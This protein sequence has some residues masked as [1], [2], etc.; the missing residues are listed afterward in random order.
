MTRRAGGWALAEAVVA[1]VLTAV[2]AAAALG[3]LVGLQRRVAGAVERAAMASGLRTAAQVIHA[4]LGSVDPGAGDLVTAAPDRMIY[5]AVRGNGI[6][7]G[8]TTDGI[9]VRT[10]TWRSLRLP[11]P[12][13]DSVLALEPGG[14]WRVAALVGPVRSATCPDGSSGLVLPMA[15]APSGGAT[16]VRTFEVMELR[17]YV[18]G[19]DSWLGLR[20]VSSGEAIQPVAG[21]FRASAIP[22]TYLD[23]SG[24]PTT[25]PHLVRRVRAVFHGITRAEGAA[26][27][28]ARAD[29]TRRDSVETVV[30]LRGGTPP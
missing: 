22:F 29:L 20:S 4:E 16:V 17:L 25:D 12:G 3:G 10:G 13:R 7:C 11:V 19:A 18:S 27:A 2:V 23:A 6:G 1:M 5:R 21:A 8:L 14:S 15:V 28:G 9:V 26:G 30:A 24:T